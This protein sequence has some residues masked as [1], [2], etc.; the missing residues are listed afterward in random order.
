[1]LPQLEW[2]RLIQG[3][4]DST[5]D[6]STGAGEGKDSFIP[7]FIASGSSATMEISVGV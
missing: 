2:L 4:V 7:L 6:A 1:M 5:I 3:I